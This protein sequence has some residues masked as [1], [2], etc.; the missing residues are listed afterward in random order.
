MCAAREL[1]HGLRSVQ[2]GSF[3][4][5][6]NGQELRLSAVQRANVPT[7]ELPAL[8]RLGVNALVLP[9]TAEAQWRE[10][11][12]LGF[13]VIGIVAEPNAVAPLLAQSPACLGWLLPYGWWTERERWQGWIATAQKWR[14]FIGVELAL[15]VDLTKWALPPEVTFVIGP[16]DLPPIGRPRL[17]RPRPDALPV[18]EPELGWLS[19]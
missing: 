14:H 5:I 4:L 10:A 17:L 2:M 15:S 8:H 13:V 18:D 19:P 16:Y 3:G 7:A 12:Q 6:W 11:E 1:R 9:L